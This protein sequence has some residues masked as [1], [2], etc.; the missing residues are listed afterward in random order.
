MVDNSIKTDVKVADDTIAMIV[1]IATTSV[2]GVV[3][4]GEGVTFKAL[5]FI[6]SNSLKKG[7]VIE[8]DEKGDNIVINIT[9]VIEQGADL[10]KTCI[11]IQEKVK[12]SV[13]SMLDLN[14]KKVIVRVAKINDI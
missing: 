8:K 7:V 14:V 13:E 12:E 3:S 2:K 4:L 6:G 5:P 9:I 1:G 10:K 11:N